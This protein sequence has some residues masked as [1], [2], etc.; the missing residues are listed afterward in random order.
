MTYS[1]LVF[2]GAVSASNIDLHFQIGYT[3]PTLTTQAVTSIA[4]TTATGNG[5]VVDDGGTTIIQRGI[6]WK[7]STGPTIADSKA[8]ASGTTGAYTVAMTGLTGNTVYYVRAY[9]INSVDT[10]YGS[11]VTFKTADADTVITYLERNSPG[12]AQILMLVP[13]FYVIGMIFIVVMF[14]RKTETITIQT[15]IGAV[16]VILVMLILLPVIIMAIGA[17]L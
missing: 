8:I 15:L 2:S 4:A 12:T 10:S 1:V 13:L 6:C 14:F 5:T 17:A 7:T 11:E 3:I 16:V 9:A